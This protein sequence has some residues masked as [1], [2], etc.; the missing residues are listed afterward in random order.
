[1]KLTPKEKALYWEDVLHKV[2]ACFGVLSAHNVLYN[3]GKQ[4]DG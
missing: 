1:M 2:K 4:D 3:T